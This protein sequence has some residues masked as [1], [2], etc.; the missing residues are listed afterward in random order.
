[1]INS[2]TGQKDITN[3]VVNY[4]LEPVSLGYLKKYQSI[5]ES[6]GGKCISKVYLGNTEK[7]RFSCKENHEWETMPI[8]I[9][10]GS[11]CPICIAQK[12]NGN[13]F[14]PTLDNYLKKY[15]K[16]AEEK[17]GKCLSKKYINAHTELTFQCNQNHIWDAMPYNIHNGN[18]CHDCELEKS[19]T[20]IEIV[21]NTNLNY[22]DR[23]KDIAQQHGGWCLSDDYLNSKSNLLFK[24][25]AGHTW[26]A[27]YNNLT[28]GAWC[29]ECHLVARRKK[30]SK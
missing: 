20:R 1:M 28:H 25:K 19:R 11:W 14:I 29:K 26:K 6:K 24:C 12:F 10:K 21:I 5:A 13:N 22:I 23:C 4:K 2:S 16:I 30:K 8:N 15:Q 18:W 17:G 9:V 7:L 3:L 27:N